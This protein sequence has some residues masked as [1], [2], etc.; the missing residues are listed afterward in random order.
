M[1]NWRQI[2]LAVAAIGAALQ[3]AGCASV[4]SGK[5]QSLKFETDPAGASC[6]ISQSSVQV[7]SFETPNAITVHRAAAPLLMSCTKQGFHQARALIGTT[8]SAAAWGNLVVGGIIGVM[9]DQGSGA[10][11]RYYDAPKLTM[12]SAA[13]PA[14]QG[15]TTLAPGVTLLPPE[16]PVAAAPSP[17]SP[18]PAAA[19]TQ[20]VPAAASVPQEPLNGVTEPSPPPAS[21]QARSRL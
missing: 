6:T 19:T 20:N 16:A 7:A 18:A 3:G 11:Y 21:G 9:I 10:A 15:S 12:V 2:S 5:E 13:E 14:P 8:T 1:I 17:L 4:T